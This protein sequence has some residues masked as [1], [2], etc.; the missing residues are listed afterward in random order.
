MDKLRQK[1]S[2][3]YRQKAEES[4]LAAMDCLSNKRYR[5]ACNRSWYTVMQSITSAAYLE[6]QNEWPGNGRP[7][8]S[9][10]AQAGLFRRIS[11]ERRRWPDNSKLATE[12][13]RLLTSRYMAD[14]LTDE[15][16]IGPKMASEAVMTARRVKSELEFL[17]A[18]SL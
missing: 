1:L 15:D 9:H 7:N 18:G 8:W 6:F 12:I 14:Y 4:Y 16:G 13:E 2:S 3:V 5:A 10:E 11:K 17:T